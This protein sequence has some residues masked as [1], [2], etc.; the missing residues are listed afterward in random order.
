MAATV[1]YAN[2][3]SRVFFSEA[4][5]RQFV[6]PIAPPSWS[7]RTLEAVE[8]VVFPQALMASRVVTKPIFIIGLP[9]SGT[10]ML[11]NLLAAHEQA[12]YVTNCMGS[13]PSALN[14]I[15]ALRRKLNLNIRG[16]RY[17]GDSL[18]TDFGGPAELMLMWGKWTGRT[19]QELDW[20]SHPVVVTPAMEAAAQQDF[21]R[22]LH[23][24]GPQAR[25]MISKDP[26][27]QPDLL[28]I[29]ALFPDAKFV[30][31][32]RDGRM[33]ANSLIKL[34]NLN[35]QQLKKIR[36][37]LLESIVTYPRIAGLARYIDEYGV[38][39]LECTARVWE[40]TIQ[41]VRRTAPQLGSFYE[42]RYEDLLAAP[43][44]ETAKLLE[45]CELPQPSEQNVNY[46]REFAGIGKIQHEN[47]YG[48]FEVVER[49][50]AK[51]MAQ[52]GYLNGP[53]E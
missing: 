3:W 24:F 53:A 31:I 16:E 6:I 8:R 29:Q 33:V 22:V 27:C 11:F 42:L 9:R 52:Y 49:V 4:F 5:E 30:H 26:M 50:A 47:R 38:D 35:N 1:E 20:E 2:W 48:G 28:T 44:Q 10:T 37:P 45:F 19:V 23:A 39:S 18:Y 25:R 12:A 14:T 46:C 17:L 21:K 34:H 43:Q 32:V 15:D 13:Y 41:L 51:T 40:D 36:H 7:R